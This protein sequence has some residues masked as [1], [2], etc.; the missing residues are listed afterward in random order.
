MRR[1]IS[2][3]EFVIGGAVGTAGLLVGGTSPGCLMPIAPPMTFDEPRETGKG[4]SVGEL[5]YVEPNENA[6]PFLE[7]AGSPWEIGRS[8]G[9][10]FAQQIRLGFERQAEW[11]KDLR[12]Y[13]D[14][15]GR[16]AVAQMLAAAKKHTPRAVAE[17]EGWAEGSGVPFDDL[18]TLNLKA[19]LAALKKE[20]TATCEPIAESQPGCSTVVLSTGD[21]VLHLHNED[22]A[23]A[24]ADLMFVL[25]CRPEDAAPY[26]VLSYPGI[27]PGNAPGVNAHGIATSANFIGTSEV[28]LGVGRYFLD[29]MI[30]ESK[31]I[32]EAIEW[33]AHPERAYAFHHVFT[34]IPEKRAVAIEVTPSKKEIVNID[35]LYIHTNHLVFKTMK[36]E[37]QDTLYVSSSSMTRWE[38]LSQWKAGLADPNSLNAKQLLEPLASHQGQPY[39]PCRHPAGDVRGFTLATVAFEAPS[40]AVT[41]YKGQ[42][43]MGRHKSYQRPAQI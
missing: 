35:G 29:R 31:N 21:Q 41:L 12:D 13:A 17:L 27:L 38:V 30:L 6:F 22:G 9:Q 33:S 20:R 15:E 11:F 18:L 5:T 28:R 1:H 7:V 43:C 4:P 14:G 24:Y 26:F 16:P 34:S 23:D 37:T 2:R 36:D 39:S 32:E 25:L 8:I 40:T 42:P 19:E 10:R 3:R